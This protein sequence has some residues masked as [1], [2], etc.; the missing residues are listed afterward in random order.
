MDESRKK[1][2][3]KGVAQVLLMRLE[4][5]RMP[6]ALALKDKVDRGERLSEFDMQFL[7]RAM[8]E[9]REARALAAKLPQY[10]EIVDR[11]ARLYEEITRKGAE[12]EQKAAPGSDRA[13]R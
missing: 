11:M 10:Q 6:R 5:H 12:N 1:S 3:D 13:G 8:H 7:K 4:S 9:G 2:R